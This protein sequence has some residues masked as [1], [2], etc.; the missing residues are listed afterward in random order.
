[1]TGDLIVIRSSLVLT[2]LAAALAALAAGCKSSGP[3]DSG[4]LDIEAVKNKAHAIL[5]SALESGQPRI[6]ALAAE[7][8]LEADRLPPVELLRGLAS[9]P[10]PRVRTTVIA[11]LG[12]LRR[13]D[14]MPLFTEKLQ[15][16][17]PTVRL[18]AAFGLAMAGNTS[19][20]NDLRDGLISPTPATRRT[21]AWLLGLMGNTSAIGMLQ[22]KLDD[23]D[24]VVVLRA[25]EAI[26]RLGGEA[27]VDT[28]RDL[29]ENE[30]HE[31]RYYATRLLG[32]VGTAAEIPWL[33]KLSQ[34][35][36]FLDVKFAAIGSLAQLGD[37]K[38]IHMLLDLL[39]APDTETRMLAARELGETGYTPAIAY[40]EPLLG[41]KEP[42]ERTVG[43]AAILSIGSGRRSWQAHLRAEP[44]SSAAPAAPTGAP[45][46]PGMTPP[47]P[48]PPTH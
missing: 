13:P 46:I 18:T 32:R 35:R 48:T 31:I 2:I 24:A 42:L 4:P 34:S 17:E 9:S 8:F 40:L 27:G 11:L 43:A 30:R 10:D 37:L 23:P 25:V 14:F 20:A 7:T 22:V 47:A 36:L 41:S 44:K 26:H 39:N 33:E 5:L 38:R 29:T 1:L 45:K 28:V 15:D 6:Q 21:A 3:R 16:P 19:Q 12:T